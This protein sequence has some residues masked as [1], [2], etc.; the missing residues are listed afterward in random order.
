MGCLCHVR[1]PLVGVR[2][3][4]GGLLFIRQTDKNRIIFHLD[5]VRRNVPA[6]GATQDFAGGDVELRAVPGAGQDFA[7]EFAFVEG[8]ADVGAVVG[9]G[10][11]AALHF[12]EANR[13]AIDFDRHQ[14]ALIYV[15]Y[16]R[17]FEIVGHGHLYTPTLHRQ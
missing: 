6:R 4:G 11:D 5:G 12:G 9:E 7:F 13:L 3:M 14:F 8:A 1:T 2:G 17:H 16:L 15:V 10:V